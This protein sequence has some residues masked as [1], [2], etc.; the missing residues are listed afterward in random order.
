MKIVPSNNLNGIPR[1]LKNYP[2]WVNWRIEKKDGKD[3]KITIIP[4]TGGKAQTDNP[5]TWGTY[6]DA[7]KFKDAHRNNDIK[8]LGFVVSGNV[9]FSGV[10][11]D[12]CRDPESGKRHGQPKS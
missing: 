1:E 4:K 10:D 12:K 8:G 2:H 6:L 9:D 11:L 3:T 5:Q 7:V